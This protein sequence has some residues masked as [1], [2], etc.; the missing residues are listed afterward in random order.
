MDCKVPDSISFVLCSTNAKAK[1]N[2][3]FGQGNGKIWM[4]DLR[5]TDNDTNIFNCSQNRFGIHDCGHHEDAGVVCYIS[6]GTVYTCA[7]VYDLDYYIYY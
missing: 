7:C 2:A 1:H 5:C 3:F 6:T 4:D